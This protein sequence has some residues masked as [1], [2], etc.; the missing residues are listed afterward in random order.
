MPQHS[1]PRIP[2]LTQRVEPTVGPAQS[3][4]TG[5]EQ[6]KHDDLPVLTNRAESASAFQPQPAPRP[7]WDEDELPVL[8]DIANIPG[9][10]ETPDAQNSPSDAASSAGRASTPETPPDAAGGVGLPQAAF[11]AATASSGANVAVLRAAL[12]AEFEQ[13]LQQA[14]DEATTTL[15]ARLEAELPAMIER[16]LNKVRPG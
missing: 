7:P 11:I 13:T 2:T 10:P 1:D 8:T 3:D 14:L 4:A 15:Q 6:A 12:Q 9:A 5:M 16:A